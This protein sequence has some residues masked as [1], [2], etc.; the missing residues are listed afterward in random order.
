MFRLQVTFFW[1]MFA[2][3]DVCGIFMLA[4]LGVTL[5]V[6]QSVEINFSIAFHNVG[7]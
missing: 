5:L 6:T 4:Y 7:L 2:A 3:G 1:V